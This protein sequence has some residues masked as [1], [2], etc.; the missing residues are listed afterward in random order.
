M[1]L[2]DDDGLALGAH[3]AVN[4]IRDPHLQLI[5]PLGGG[6]DP[7]QL[8]D[9]VLAGGGGGEAGYQV[10]LVAHVENNQLVVCSPAAQTDHVGEI[11]PPHHV[12]LLVSQLVQLLLTHHQEPLSRLLEPVD[13]HDLGGEDDVVDA[14]PGPDLLDGGGVLRAHV[15]LAEIVS[16]P[17]PVH[18]PVP[19]SLTSWTARPHQLPGQ[20]LPLQHVAVLGRDPPDDHVAPPPQEHRLELPGRLVES[21]G[22]RGPAQTGAVVLHTAAVPEISE[23]D[24]LEGEL[25]QN[26]SLESLLQSVN[27]GPHLVL[28]VLAPYHPADRKPL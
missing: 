14:V 24:G 4:F 28:A 6:D 9:P 18:P 27:V 17:P 7:D 20:Q 13:L 1:I 16:V 26:Y 11:L 22:G 21:P 2:L 5:L 10:V 23:S 19:P 3:R 8:P 12:A 15:L 25:S